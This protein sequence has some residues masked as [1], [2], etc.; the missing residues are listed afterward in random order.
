MPTN[1]FSDLNLSVF[2]NCSERSE[3][4]VHLYVSSNISIILWPTLT[5]TISRMID[6]FNNLGSRERLK[7][8]KMANF[9]K[10]P[11][12][13]NSVEELNSASVFVSICES[14]WYL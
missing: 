6:L 12:R 11:L 8:C 2:S 7:K 5:Q 1:S 3:N 10:V 4:S 13:E 14:I 9:I